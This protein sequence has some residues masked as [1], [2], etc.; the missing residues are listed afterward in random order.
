MGGY[1]K[2]PSSSPATS[3][4]SR[5]R[6]TRTNGASFGQ[7]R[8]SRP[9]GLP[10][11]R[12]PPRRS[13]PRPATSRAN[14]P[15]RPHLFVAVAHAGKDCSHQAACPTDAPPLALLSPSQHGRFEWYEGRMAAPMS[16]PERLSAV[17][18][19][20][21]RLTCYRCDHLVVTQASYRR[22]VTTLLGTPLWGGTRAPSYR[23]E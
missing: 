23:P 22:G 8:I 4:M 17:R 12:L 20:P 9:P 16:V 19:P 3:P 10:R 14:F 11:T 15:T 18:H 13:R 2:R 6:A 1:G 7:Q 5:S 21:V